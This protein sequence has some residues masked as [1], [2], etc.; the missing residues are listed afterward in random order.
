MMTRSTFYGE[1]MSS[2]TPPIAYLSVTNGALWPF[3]GKD[4]NTYV[5]DVHRAAAERKIG[6]TVY[7]SYVMNWVANDGLDIGNNSAHQLLFAELPAREKWLSNSQS[8]DGADSVL[9]P[10]DNEYIGFNHKIGKRYASHVAFA[11]GHVE[12]LLE[13]IS[14]AGAAP[15]DT[16]LQRLTEQLCNGEEIESSIRKKMK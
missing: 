12:S 11:D 2:G 15:S 4:M 1:K 7:R 6:K 9:D 16:D 13:P 14:S 10:E 8:P 5:C 3:V